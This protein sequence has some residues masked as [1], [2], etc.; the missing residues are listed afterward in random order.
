[1]RRISETEYI[2][3]EGDAVRMWHDCPKYRE[4]RAGR[5][6]L[7]KVSEKGGFAEFKCK[8]CGY[9]RKLEIALL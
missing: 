7:E 8:L 5:I 9:K 6:E 1:M 2:V 3:K 4:D